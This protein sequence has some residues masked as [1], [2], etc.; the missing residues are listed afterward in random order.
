MKRFAYLFSLA[1]GAVILSLALTMSCEGPAGPAGT[2]GT[3]GTNGENGI[4]ANETCKV[5]HNDET[6]MLAKQIQHGASSHQT[7]GNFE[8]SDKDCAACHTHEGFID[9]ME[10]GSQ[11]ASANINNPTPQNCRTCHKVHNAYDDNDWDLTYD[12]PVKLWNNDVTI[13]LAT[14]NLCANCHQPWK[15]D[16]NPVMGGA[17]VIITSAY[18][19]QHYGIPSAALWGTAGYEF[20]DASVDYPTPGSKMHAT[21]GCKTCHM[22]TAY[23][24]QAGGHTFKMSYSYHGRDVDNV[25]GCKTCHDSAEDFGFLGAQ[26]EVTDL[27]D[28]LETILL[29]N[30]WIDASAHIVPATYTADQAGA[31]LNLQYVHHEGSHGIHNPSYIKALLK[32]T[33]EAIN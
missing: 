15:P 6:K 29:A 12:D 30:G 27:T 13:D 26:A 31:V 1:T 21:T 5:C 23:G 3:D 18:W 33:I 9:R 8:R 14:G 28:S 22:A 4:D 11:E 19:G 7:G 20:T 16:P 17:D 10:S 24:D 2:A 25:A 32:N